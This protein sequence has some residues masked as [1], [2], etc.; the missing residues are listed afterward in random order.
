M[1]NFFLF[2]TFK[3]HKHHLL[4]CS[5]LTLPITGY[6]ANWIPPHD[7]WLR[8]ELEHQASFHQIAQPI[9]TWPLPTSILES[10]KQKL[11][12]S[13]LLSVSQREKNGLRLRLSASGSQPVLTH[14][15]ST[16]R[17]KS[18]SNI[19]YHFSNNNIS[20]QISSQ[21]IDNE[22]SD[23]TLKFDNSFMNIDIDHW[24]VGVGAIDRWWGPGWDTGLILSSNARPLPS[25][26][27]SRNRSNAF[28]SKWLSWIGPW[29]LV[30]FMGQL[31]QERVVPNALLWGM[32]IAFKP[33]ASWEIG[34]SRTAMWAG[35]GRPK[36][37]SVFIDLLAGNDNFEADDAGK[38]EEPGNQLA[39]FD[40]KYS[41]HT[42]SIGY[43]FYG[44]V[45]GEDEA[46]GLPSRPIAML[47]ASLHFTLFQRRATFYTEFSDTA[48][49]AFQ[50]D[51]M[52]GSAYRH[53][54][55][56]TG[57]LYKG[58]TLGSTYD[59][60]THAF[61]LGALMNLPSNYKFKMT[62]RLLNLNRDNTT[63]ASNN[64]VSA[65][66]LRTKQA[67]FTLA[68]NWRKLSLQASYLWNSDNTEDSV[69]TLRSLAEL[70][71]EFQF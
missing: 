3:I 57:Y 62:L 53:G 69:S 26:Y 38:A 41:N 8:A 17:E 68:K 18:K 12:Q 66:K 45:I 55:Y 24:T 54:T 71:A 51:K 61:V 7:P 46:G 67:A 10:A 20:T 13:A 58:V 22:N 19:S 23:P 21:Y 60:D 16:N 29:T 31:E 50:S 40:F 27:L 52:Y 63:N 15:G 36:D 5:L 28:Q 39:G 37:L 64:S 42:P 43:S 56:S 30:T 35:D 70:S 32:R 1:R 14:F 9:S 11:S 47:G 25:V 44:E 34:L 49:D 2:D 4:L 48:M 65:T 33:T 59:N 6:S